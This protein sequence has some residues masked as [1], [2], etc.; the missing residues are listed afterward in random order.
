MAQLVGSPEQLQKQ[1]MV[2]SPVVGDDRYNTSQNL[3]GLGGNW[4]GL[5]GRWKGLPLLFIVA[6]GTN[7]AVSEAVP[8]VS[9]S[10]F[11][12]SSQAIPA[13]SECVLFLF[14]ENT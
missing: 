10:H 14:S 7:P 1:Y 5:D 12:P 3:E 2:S 6:F 13:P 9:F 11:Q 8:A 4:E